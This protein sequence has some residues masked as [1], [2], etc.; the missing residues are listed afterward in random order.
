MIENTCRKQRYVYGTTLDLVGK[1]KGL[2]KFDLQEELKARKFQIKVGGNMLGVFDFG[3]GKFGSEAIFIPRDV[4]LD[5]EED[6]NYLI[7]FVNDENT[8]YGSS[9]HSI[10]LSPELSYI[11]L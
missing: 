5:L 8:G 7:Y 10:F 4:G 11:F 9:L 1:V 2:V 3:P 6:D